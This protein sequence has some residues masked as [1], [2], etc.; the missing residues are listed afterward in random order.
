MRNLPKGLSEKG[1]DPLE[2]HRFTTFL[3][4]SPE[5]DTYSFIDNRNVPETHSLPELIARYGIT[6]AIELRL[7]YNYEVGGAGSPVSGN[8]SDEFEETSELEREAR[9]IYGT[10]WRVTQQIG[11]IPQSSLVLNSFTPLSGIDTATQF[12]AT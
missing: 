3:A 2:T 12:S 4:T 6:E 9:V 11:W 7:G 10:K 5:R 1:A 8:V